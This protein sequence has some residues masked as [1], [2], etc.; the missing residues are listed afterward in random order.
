ML[1]RT[2]HMG[3]AFPAESYKSKCTI[4]AQ[5]LTSG[6]GSDITLGVVIS[7]SHFCLMLVRA[8]STFCQT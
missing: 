8:I 1:R 5:M 7:F 3:A 6:L 2:H 4:K